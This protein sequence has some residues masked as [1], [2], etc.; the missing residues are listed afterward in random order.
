MI[1][2]SLKIICK[3]MARRNFGENY[4]QVVVLKFHI[5][6]KIY[7][8]IIKYILRIMSKSPGNYEL[9]KFK[10]Q[11]YGEATPSTNYLCKDWAE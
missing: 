2:K 5:F 4:I 7:S 6:W 11:F 8:L 10:K 1:S 3:T 9:D